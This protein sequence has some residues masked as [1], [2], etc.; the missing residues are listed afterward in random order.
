MRRRIPWLSVA[1]G[2]VL[3]F[4]GMLI[5]A[6]AQ[7][8]LHPDRRSRDELPYY[9]TADAELQRK[10]ADLYR[11]L[12]CRQCHSIWSVKS[13]MQAVP[14]PRLDGIGSLRS[15]DWLFRYFSA[16]DPQSM[17]PSRLKPK[18]RHPSYADLPEKQRRLLARYFASLKVR[19]WYFEETL[20]A[21]Q[22][23]LTGKPAAERAVNEGEAP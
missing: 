14:A 17:L 22:E 3:L 6:V 13:V 15:E 8:L 19:D 7:S 11:K 9:T 4:A 12:N 18:Y 10:G 5:L 1:T 21:E 20:R 23:K 16:A 2:G